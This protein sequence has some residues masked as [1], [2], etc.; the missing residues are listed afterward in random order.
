MNIPLKIAFLTLIDITQKSIRGMTGPFS[1]GHTSDQYGRPLS[2]SQVRH[3]PELFSDSSQS[4]V[5]L[6]RKSSG[7]VHHFASFLFTRIS[8]LR[9]MFPQMLVNV[10]CGSHSFVN[11]CQ[12]YL[13]YCIFARLWQ[14]LSSISNMAWIRFLASF[15]FYN[16]IYL[17]LYVF[18]HKIEAK[19]C[20][21]V[22]NYCTI[23]P[24]LIWV[25]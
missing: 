3:F 24:N 4:L 2:W 16:L 22:Y 8:Q 5:R 6:E 11:Y 17:M 20:I 23:C 19:A 12:L 21:C 10:W 14:R 25:I 18:V 9:Q 13:F 7:T 1:S 15:D